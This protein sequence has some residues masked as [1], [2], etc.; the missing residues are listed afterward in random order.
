MAVIDSSVIRQALIKR[1]PP[2]AY[3]LMFEVADATGAKQRR[4]ADALAMGLWPSRGLTLT[5]FEIKVSRTDWLKELRSPEK[6]EAIAAYCSAWFLVVSNKTI[7]KDGELPE[8]WGLM[9]IGDNGS[10][11][12]VKPAPSQTPQPI[13]QEFLAAMLR[14]AAKPAVFT[15]QS[16]LAKAREDGRRSAVEHH[17]RVE[18][19][20]RD[21]LNELRRQV[22]DFEAH[23]GMRIINRWGGADPKRIGEVVRQVLDG[24][25]DFAESSL[26]RIRDEAKKMMEHAERELA[27]FKNSEA[28]ESV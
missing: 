9:T 27:W 6:A 25:H 17:E 23:A 1:Y 21:E 14:A 16:A 24:K 5:G 2:E 26:A 10:L 15:D 22:H 28:K 13:T 11:V 19:K 4:W 8:K 12:T 18:N 3:A 20:L 7:V